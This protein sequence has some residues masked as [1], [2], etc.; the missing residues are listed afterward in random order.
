MTNFPSTPVLKAEIT[1]ALD[2]RLI[3]RNYLTSRS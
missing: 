2:T 3:G 1:R